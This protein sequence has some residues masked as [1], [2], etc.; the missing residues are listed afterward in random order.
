MSGIKKYISG[1]KNYVKRVCHSVKLDMERSRKANKKKSHGGGLVIFLL[2]V[3]GLA[4]VYTTAERAGD[5]KGGYDAA[6]N[7]YSREIKILSKQFN[8]DY[9]YLMA[10]I[11]L[12]SSGRKDITPRFEPHVYDRL[13]AVQKNEH[14]DL[15]S[16][17]Y[18]DIAGADDNALRNLASSWGPFQ[19]MGYKCIHL[20]IKI[21]DL[22]G[23]NALYWGVSWIDKTYGDYV[24][25]GRYADAF[26]IHNTGRPLPKDGRYLTYDKNYV[27]NGLKYMKEFE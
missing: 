17:T 3:V 6:V 26:H 20:N 23:S 15:E 5:N 14:S 13:K 27:P 2:I 21:K 18:E 10:L 4:I 19:L 8:L 1:K 9:K 11:M 12:E 25:K 22:R 16:I 24:R 7:N